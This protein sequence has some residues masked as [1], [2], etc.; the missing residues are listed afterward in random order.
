VG[1][2][3]VHD[4]DGEE[5]HELVFARINEGYT[6]QD[7]IKAEGEKG[8][9]ELIGRTVAKPDGKGKPLKVGKLEPGKYAMVC[10]FRTKDGEPH[11]SLGQ[12]EQFEIE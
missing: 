2:V 5:D 4:D 10:V 12:Q 11:Y 3:S 8:T 7:A 1:H 6:L 9:A